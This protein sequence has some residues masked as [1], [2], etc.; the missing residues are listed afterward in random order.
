MV[1]YQS[2]QLSMN[3]HRLHDFNLPRILNTCATWDIAMRL[4]RTHMEMVAGT[5]VWTSEDDYFISAVP[6]LE[7]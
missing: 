2:T 1:I 3:N 5:D 4:I 6:V 7:S